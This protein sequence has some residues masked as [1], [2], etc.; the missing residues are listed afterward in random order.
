M[1]NRL[2]RV[3]LAIAAVWIC[4]PTITHAV[5]AVAP[6]ILFVENQ[7][8]LN[9]SAGQYFMIALA[10]NR[11]TGFGW[12]YAHFARTGV[13]QLLGNAYSSPSGAMAGAGG[14]EI[15]LF[16]ALTAG[17]TKLTL[18]YR[19]SWEKKP[20]ARTLTFD[21]TVSGGGQFVSALPCVRSQV[22]TI[23]L[24]VGPAEYQSGRMVLTNGATLRVS[25][26]PAPI[27]LSDF[28]AGDSVVACYGNERTW[29]DAPR[30]RTTTV[31]D[32]RSGGY[33]G[34]LIGEW[35]RGTSNQ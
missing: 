22:A 4:I 9:V 23:R 30:S 11:T 10:S 27:T 32:L 17:T 26:T 1:R 14:K 15:L 6:S 5:G 2:L 8:S 18:S 12:S 25:G 35:L 13:V 33:F 20:P 16:R 34:S 24:P 7:K 28:R 3:V 21:I 29:A 31:L 19:R